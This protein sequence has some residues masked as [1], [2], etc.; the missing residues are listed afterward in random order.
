MF[1]SNPLFYPCFC[2]QVTLL[3]GMMLTPES[4]FS[5]EVR[6]AESE[7][8]AHLLRAHAPQLKEMKFLS[9]SAGF[10]EDLEHSFYELCLG[11]GDRSERD[12]AALHDLIRRCKICHRPGAFPPFSTG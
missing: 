10:Q 5:P 11:D 3:S 8:Q 6:K 7:R 12:K 9:H 1:M 4:V 2:F